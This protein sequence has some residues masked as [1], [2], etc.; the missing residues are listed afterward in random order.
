MRLDHP[1]ITPV[2]ANATEEQRELLKA[3]DRPG[4]VLNIYGTLANKPDAARSFLTWGAYVLRRSSVDARLRELAILR[5]GWLCKAGYEWMQ[6][7][8]LGLTVGLT[9]VEID[10]I[11]LRPDASSWR[12]ADLSVLHAVDEMVSDHFISPPT[13]A[14]LGET[15][16][17]E[18]R[19]D[20]VFVVGHYIQVCVILNS[21]G[22]QAEPG[23]EIDPDLKVSA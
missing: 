16:S 8:R 12:S 22:I 5:V 6:H 14:L 18:E 4:G 3:Y 2:G 21:L 11:K 1:R 13:W 19:M 23:G 7:S 10:R 9:Q 20:L 15:L 17:E